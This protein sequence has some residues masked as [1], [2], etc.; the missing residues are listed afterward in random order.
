ML[1][2][3]ERTLSAHGEPGR[4]EIEDG[5]RASCEASR[6]IACDASVVEVTQFA[7]GSV[8]DVGRRTRTI[9]PALRRALEV[10]DRGCP[11]PPSPGARRRLADRMVG[12]RAAGVRGSQ[13]SNAFRGRV[14][15]T[16]A[17]G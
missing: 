8:L 2:V 14:A 1:H 16:R 15:A 13:W 10:R 6:R 9:P 11:T 17:C 12:Q 5:T 3:D 4:S 7:D